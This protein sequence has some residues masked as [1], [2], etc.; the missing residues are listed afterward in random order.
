MTAIL[1]TYISIAFNHLSLISETQQIDSWRG[2]TSNGGCSRSIQLAWLLLLQ[3]EILH[4]NYIG[5]N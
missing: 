1:P 3:L 5:G 4:S 2:L